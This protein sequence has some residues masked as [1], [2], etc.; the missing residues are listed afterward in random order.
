MAA[1]ERLICPAAALVEGGDGVR[2]EVPAPDGVVAAFAV[3]YGGRVYGYVNRCAHV[4][5]EL[6]WLPGRFFDLSGH[7]LICAA[8][9]ARYEP[10]SGR[11]VAGPCRGARLVPLAL[12]ER[13]GK[14]YLKED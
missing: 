6:D 14:V 5:L 2:F 10:H 3:R 13:D 8:H 11:C 9:G 12:V 4:P 1:A 7:Y